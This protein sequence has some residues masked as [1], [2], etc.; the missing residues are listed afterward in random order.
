MVS[1]PSVSLPPVQALLP[2][3][4]LFVPYTRCSPQSNIKVPPETNQLASSPAKPP[5]LS[6]APLP[7]ARTGRHARYRL[8][9][10]SLGR[11]QR[12]NRHRPHFRQQSL[13]ST[14]WHGNTLHVLVPSDVFST[15]RQRPRSAKAIRRS[16]CW[17]EPAPA[18]ALSRLCTRPHQQQNTSR[19]KSKTDVESSQAICQAA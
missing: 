17:W 4:C 15:R 19:G 7:I 9:P 11:H 13:P 10:A 6:P 5:V 8:A 12:T 18:N 2:T 3:R 14:D 1:A 16:A